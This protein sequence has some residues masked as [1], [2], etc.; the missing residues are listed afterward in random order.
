MIPYTKEQKKFIDYNGEESIILSAVAGSGKTASAV[1]RL[2]KMLSDGIDPE[3]IIFF[4]FTN[5]AVDELRSRIEGNI[6]ITT[7]HSYT[8]SQL[9]KMGK[10]KPVSTFYEFAAWY[11]ENYKPKP[12]M[13]V[14]KKMEFQKTM[15]KFYEDGANISATFSAY[16]L[17]TSDNIRISKPKYF[18]EYKKFLRDTKSRDFSDLLIETEKLSMNPQYKKYFEGT[19]DYIFIDEYQDTSTLQLK[20]LLTIQAKQYFLM[21]DKFQSIF[22]FSGANCDAIEALLKQQRATLEF[23]LT[24]NFRSRIS[25]VEHA[26]NF[27]DLKAV[28]FSTEQGLVNSTLISEYEMWDMIEDDKPLAILCRTN[29]VIKDL[30]KEFLRKKVKMRYFNYITPKDIEYFNEGKMNTA[31]KK[32]MDSVTP[33]FN[34]SFAMINFINENQNSNKFITS[35]HKSKGREYPRV[36]VVNSFSPD[37]LVNQP[38]L[39]E[40]YSFMNELGE[41]DVEARNVH[42]VACTRP[43]EELYFLVYEM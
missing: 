11:K 18:D 10:F 24:Q 26:N 37:Q 16:K 33:Y 7:I 2:N 42:Y 9:A 1:G 25:I 13:P 14:L 22:G 23:T 4:S 6:R 39:L 15:D 29:R 21:G 5:D 36:L 40:A 30:E 34:S 12:Y 28:P 31:I 3:R 27:S 35:I 19:Y 32:K 17:Q 20:I 43:K 8:S 38:H 41:I